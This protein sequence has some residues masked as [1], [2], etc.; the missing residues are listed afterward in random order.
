M[1]EDKKSGLAFRTRSHES[2]KTMEDDSI[3]ASDSA[4]PTLRDIAAATGFGLTTV[5]Y[6]LNNSPRVSAQTRKKVQKAA[7]KMGYSKNPLVGAL[8]KQVRR[9]KIPHYK[10]TIAFL[11]GY[12]ER[13]GWRQHPFIVEQFECAQRAGLA[14]GY[15]TEPFWARDPDM[16]PARL[17]QMLINRGIHGVLVSPFSERGELAGF[18]WQYF[19]IVALGHSLEAPPVHRGVANL[20]QA[21]ELVLQKIHSLGFRNPLLIMPAL[22]NEKT[23]HQYDIGWP[24]FMKTIFGGGDSWIIHANEAEQIKEELFSVIREKLIDVVVGFGTDITDWLRTGG[25]K[26]PE[27][28]SYVSLNR[29]DDKTAGACHRWG[30]IASSAVQFLISQIESNI[31][32][33]PPEIPVLISCPAFWQDG[34]TVRMADTTGRKGRIA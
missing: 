20:L 5:S 4:S 22:V 26:V 3:K 23:K 31:R 24:Y 16:D 18:P 28:L 17:G 9:G 29:M 21:L 14:Q 15:K 1:H 2:A 30:Y 10:E 7:I 6:A 25:L 32:P 27:Q 33:G 8:M 19:H 34:P 12:S 13:D 11:T